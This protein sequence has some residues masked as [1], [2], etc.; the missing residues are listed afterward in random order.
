MLWVK[1]MQKVNTAS[2][3]IQCATMMSHLQA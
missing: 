1:A 2:P 3:A